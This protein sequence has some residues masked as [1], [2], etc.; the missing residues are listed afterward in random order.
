[1]LTTSRINMKDLIRMI[2][3]NLATQHGLHEISLTLIDKV[4]NATSSCILNSLQHKK[5]V[6]WSGV[7]A[8]VIQSRKP[9]MRRNP[10]NGAEIRIPAK[11]VV[12][13]KLF[14]S[15]A[16]KCALKPTKTRRGG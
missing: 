16:A 15:F 14:K 12:K 1:M 11:E 8:F 9:T 3:V 5:E 13:M 2:K 7:G 10:Q 6:N 4:L